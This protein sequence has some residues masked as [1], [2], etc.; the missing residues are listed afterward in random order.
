MVWPGRAKWTFKKKHWVNLFLFL[1]IL[2]RWKKK[3]KQHQPTS[4]KQS[5]VL[6][7]KRNS[8]CR[9]ECV[10]QLPHVNQHPPPP[11]HGSGS[12]DSTIKATFVMLRFSNYHPPT[13]L[14][15]CLWRCGESATWPAA[16]STWFQFQPGCTGVLGE[17]GS[18]LERAKGL[19]DSADFLSHAL[20]PDTVSAMLRVVSARGCASQ[21]LGKR[22]DLVPRALISTQRLF[23]E[24]VRCN[25]YLHLKLIKMWAVRTCAIWDQFY[26]YLQ[27]HTVCLA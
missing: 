14:S 4:L 18:V 13:P 3:K 22:W 21:E 19:T 17:P 1:M 7:T 20:A 11:P 25:S 15:N 10:K 26:L 23:S 9:S 27:W 8:S 6:S 16:H 2:C 12:C 5:R 24:R